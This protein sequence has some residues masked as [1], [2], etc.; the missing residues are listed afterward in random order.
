MAKPKNQVGEL[1][2]RGRRVAD[3]RGQIVAEDDANADAG[4]THA[5]AGNTGTNIF[6]G[7]R[8]H[9]KLLFE[10]CLNDWHSMAWVKRIIEVDAS[11]DGEDVRLQQSHQQFQGGERC[12]QS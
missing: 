1:S 5:D 12:R 10:G 7:R 11:Q 8:V 2:G 3:R 9:S 6:C 4:A